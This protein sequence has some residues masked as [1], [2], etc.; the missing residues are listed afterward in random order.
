MFKKIQLII[1]MSI[2]VFIGSLNVLFAYQQE[3]DVEYACN[4]LIVDII[5]FNSSVNEKRLQVSLSF[6]S[7]RD[8]EAP[9]IFLTGNSLR[10][11]FHLRNQEGI[12]WDIPASA[13]AFDVN[14][15]AE[16]DTNLAIYNG[17]VSFAPLKLIEKAVRDGLQ[18]TATSM[19]E[20]CEPSDVPRLLQL[21]F[22][23][24]T[25][26]NIGPNINIDVTGLIADVFE[27]LSPEYFEYLR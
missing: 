25:Y 4:D 14:L 13:R 8:I 21:G 18:N 5:T 17:R 15:G 10:L 9:P 24:R 20:N 27:E 26:F 23:T 3:D 12:V 22:V 11:S 1:G 16:E 6:F 2:F 19:D 7:N